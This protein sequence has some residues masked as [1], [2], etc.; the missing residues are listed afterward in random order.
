MAQKQVIKIIGKKLGMTQLFDAT[1]KSL[2]CTVIKV[3]P[4]VVTQI[5]SKEGTDGYEAIQ[6]AS[7]EITA[8]DARTPM[9]RV[10]S[11]RRG[12][13]NKVGISAH[14]RLHECR[15]DDSSTY[16]VGQQV[17]VE[18]FT[19]IAH[20][21]ISAVTKGKG[22]AGVIKAHN[23]GGG[24]ASH[25][26]GFHR[27]GGS[28]GMRSTPGQCLPGTKKPKRLGGKIQTTQNLKVERIDAENGI[29][30]VRGAVPGHRGSSL[31]LSEAVKK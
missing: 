3:A 8:K 5:K 16:E 23:F 14:R 7:E 11:P 25:G 15:L 10:T 4:N 13:F 20:L 12:L 28:T 22:C 9:K 6:L 24:P 29:L 27:T 19:E 26:S 17:G 2:P 31:L 21:D 18:V 30:V 1:G